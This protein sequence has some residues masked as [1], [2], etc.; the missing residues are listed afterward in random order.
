MDEARSTSPS[1]AA[2]AS[3]GSVPKFADWI[4]QQAV[5]RARLFLS[6]KSHRAQR[7]DDGV[8]FFAVQGAR[9]RKKLEGNIG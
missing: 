8:D 2:D 5:A 4:S 9:A 3:P 1:S 7:L 6:A